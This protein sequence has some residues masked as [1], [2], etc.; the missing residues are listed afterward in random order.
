MPFCPTVAAIA[1]SVEE[2]LRRVPRV[3]R[4]ADVD[5][6]KVTFGVVVPRVFKVA[7]RRDHSA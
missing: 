2:R 3:Q 4:I 7:E 6:R 5:L 1:D